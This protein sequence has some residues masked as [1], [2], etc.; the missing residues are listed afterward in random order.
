MFLGKRVNSILASHNG[1][2]VEDGFPLH[3]MAMPET[4]AP[5]DFQNI[6]TLRQESNY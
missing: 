5:T 1:P 3:D 2:P 4:A 6:E